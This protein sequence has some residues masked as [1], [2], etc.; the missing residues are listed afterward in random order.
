M[1]SSEVASDILQSDQGSAQKRSCI[2]DASGEAFEVMTDLRYSALSKRAAEV[3]GP[4]VTAI[5]ASRSAAKPLPLTLGF[6][7]VMQQT[8][9]FTWAAINASQQG[10]VRLPSPRWQQGSKLT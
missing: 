6:G 3:L 8:T 5:R 4:T 7:S 1:L 9:R 10:G 2:K